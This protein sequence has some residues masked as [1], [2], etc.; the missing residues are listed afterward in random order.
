MEEVTFIGVAMTHELRDF[1][2]D[3]KELSQSLT[4]SLHEALIQSVWRERNLFRVYL[5][6]L[7][8]LESCEDRLAKSEE[9]RETLIKELNEV[10]R[11]LNA[12]TK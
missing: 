7:Q 11:G 6:T 1:P 5:E 4:N 2:S 3:A 12:R 10:I 8:R 9:V